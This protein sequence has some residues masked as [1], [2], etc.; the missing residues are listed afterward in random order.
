MD[1][2]CACS[3]NVAWS[4]A[5]ATTPPRTAVDANISRTPLVFETSPCAEDLTSLA[6]ATTDA[7]RTRSV[8]FTELVFAVKDA[9][10]EDKEDAV[11]DDAIM[12][13][14]VTSDRR[15]TAGA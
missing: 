5:D 1:S 11:R 10:T 4:A 12:I 15:E 6:R 14:L 3:G 8:R 9:E 13:T 7:R 2:A